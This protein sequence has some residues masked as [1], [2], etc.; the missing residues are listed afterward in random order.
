MAVD[1]NQL[2][3]KAQQ[4]VL[5]KMQEQRQAGSNPLSRSQAVTAPLVS[6]RGAFGDAQ[7]SRGKYGNRK[8]VRV[9]NGRKIVFDSIKE[10]RRYDELMLRQQ[11]G[12]IRDLRLQVGFTLKEPYTT[13][14]GLRVRAIR[15]DAD[16]TYWE[17]VPVL[18][19][20]QEAN[21]KRKRITTAPAEPRNDW[22]TDCH[23]AGASRNDWGGQ[24]EWRYVVEDVKSNPTRTKTYM[25]KKK[26]MADLGYQIRE[27]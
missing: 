23:V 21:E 9:V 20:M 24:D 8:D 15:Y 18:R 13:A 2:P 19:E 17:R 26:L 5:R 3:L 11:A 14:D 4:Q 25:M 27:V 7:E 22:E 6:S 10:A 12:Q 1:I 16:F